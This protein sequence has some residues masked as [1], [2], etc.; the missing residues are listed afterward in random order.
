[1]IEM[2]LVVALGL[3]VTFWKLSW[4]AR[5][6]M[7]SHPVAMDIAVFALLVC[8][9]W[10]TYS[11]VMV[12]TVG[13]LVCSMVLGALRWAFGYMARGAHVPGKFTIKG[14]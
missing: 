4:R 5:L 6:R 2:G 7:L 11:G 12:A 1:M 8:L 3:C 10:G 13:A 9:H 14:A